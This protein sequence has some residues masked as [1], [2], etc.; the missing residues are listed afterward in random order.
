M[1]KIDKIIKDLGLDDHIPYEIQQD[2]I[3]LGIFKKGLE[4]ILEGEMTLK[5]G[6]DKNSLILKQ[7]ENK[8]NGHRYRKLDTSERISLYRL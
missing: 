5:L 8:R 3:M 7:T 4:T 2:E 1:D 6:Y